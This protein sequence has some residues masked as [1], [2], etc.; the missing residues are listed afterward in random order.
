[1]VLNFVSGLLGRLKRTERL[2]E[3]EIVFT[4]RGVPKNMKKIKGDHITEINRD[5]FSYLDFET[6]KETRVPMRH[7]LEIWMDKKSV[8]KRNNVKK[9]ARKSDKKNAKTRKAVTKKNAGKS[10]IAKT[11]RKKTVIK[12]SGGKKSKSSR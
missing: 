9:S 2:P 8:W 1:M 3:S 4:H 11:A 10:K 5:S 6:K 7:V 12:K